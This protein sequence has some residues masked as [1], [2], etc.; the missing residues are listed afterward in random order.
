MQ[1]FHPLT[2]F[3]PSLYMLIRRFFFILLGSVSST[4]DKKQMHTQTVAS[5]KDKCKWNVRLINYINNT[6]GFC[7]CYLFIIITVEWEERTKND[8]TGCVTEKGS[9]I[10]EPQ[11]KYRTLSWRRHA[12]ILLGDHSLLLNL[13]AL[14]QC[15]K[16]VIFYRL[17]DK[18]CPKPFEINMKLIGV[19]LQE[20]YWK[21]TSRVFFSACLSVFY[22]TKHQSWFAQW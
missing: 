21:W 18:I 11:H 1:I 12:I 15:Q 19:M 6:I 5:R 9:A 3:F 8:Q 17:S 20:I 13:V 2:V 16:V 14:M 7:G 4:T 10:K 22:F